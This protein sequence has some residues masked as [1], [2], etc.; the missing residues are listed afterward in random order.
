MKRILG[1]VAAGIAIGVT[2]TALAANSARTPVT[3]DCFTRADGR[4]S[5]NVVLKGSGEFFVR[6]PSLDL[7]CNIFSNSK[8][9]VP[10]SMACDRASFP[11]PPVCIDGKYDSLSVWVDKFFM[12]IA[13]PDECKVSLNGSVRITHPGDTTRKY[14]RTP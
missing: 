10:Q 1:G 7:S 12:Y 13:L 11:P 3:T 2:A 6:I 4:S 8:Q 5:C 9:G 14:S